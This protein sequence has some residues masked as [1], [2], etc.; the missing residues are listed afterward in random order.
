MNTI[1]VGLFQEDKDDV[2]LKDEVKR[3]DGTLS[4]SSSSS[5]SSDSEDENDNKKNGD[6]KKGKKKDDSQNDETAMQN[7]EYKSK[8]IFSILILGTIERIEYNE[9]NLVVTA[10]STL[11]KGVFINFNEIEIGDKIGEGGN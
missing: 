10:E 4:S 5:S 9:G 11:G 7:S 8:I 3:N 6:D 1:S 2:D